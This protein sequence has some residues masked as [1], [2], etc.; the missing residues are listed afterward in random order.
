MSGDSSDISADST[1]LSLSSDSSADE[2]GDSDH[3]LD[4]DNEQEGSAGSDTLSDDLNDSSDED[5]VEP[6]S[7]RLV[8]ISFWYVHGLGVKSSQILSAS[9]KCVGCHTK[10]LQGVRYKTK[11]RHGCFSICQVWQ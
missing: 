5:G 8:N 2:D 1:D 4:L 6:A 7:D 9:R 10:Y 11:Q 3:T